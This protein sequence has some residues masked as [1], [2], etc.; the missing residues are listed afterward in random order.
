MKSKQASYRCRQ[1]QHYLK[2][3]MFEKSGSAGMIFMYRGRDTSNQMKTVSG[4]ALRYL[5]AKGFKEEVY[6]TGA[7]TRMPNLNRNAAIER[8]VPHV[9]YGKSK[10][11]W[12]GFS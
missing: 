1:G 7:Y 11:S 6:Y 5:T 10:T 8:I 12:P 2:I 4:S 3:E 9:V